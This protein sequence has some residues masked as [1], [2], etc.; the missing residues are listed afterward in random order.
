MND[1][2]RRSIRAIRWPIWLGALLC[3]FAAALSGAAAAH[4]PVTQTA[5]ALATDQPVVSTAATVTDQDSCL[6]GI[7]HDHNRCCAGQGLCH[8]VALVQDVT[9][10]AAAQ[11]Q[12]PAPIALAERT[13]SDVAPLF[14]PPKSQR[15]S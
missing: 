2:P 8:T 13:G 9:V 4:A 14:H 7:R 5:I 1:A 15:R 10:A 11:R 12:G 6:D 3:L